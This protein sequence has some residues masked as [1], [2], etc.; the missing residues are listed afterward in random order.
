MGWTT[1]VTTGQLIEV[2]RC[3]GVVYAVATRC[4]YLDRTRRGCCSPGDTS[5]YIDAHRAK[6][7]RQRG[8]HREYEQRTT[9]RS[10]HDN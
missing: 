9:G 6:R 4:D 7:R 8:E 2:P 3:P 1:L 10:E 5:P